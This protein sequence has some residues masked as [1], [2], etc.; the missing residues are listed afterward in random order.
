MNAKQENRFSMAKSVLKALDDNNNIVNALAA[1]AAAKTELNAVVTEIDTLTQAQALQTTAEEKTNAGKAAVVIAMEVIA[2]AKAYAL[3]KKKPGVAASFNYGTHELGK[4]RD[5]ILVN[6]MQLVHDNA[7]LIVADITDYG[8]DAAKLTS[9]QKA[10]DAY[11]G[12]LTAPKA[13][14][15]NRS[16]ATKGIATAFEKLNDVIEKIDNMV[17]TK[18]NSHQDFYNTYKAVRKVGDKGAKPKEEKQPPVQKN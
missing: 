16:A 2:A 1:L 9:L 15:A 7:K 4:M 12:L 17:E 18:R 11:A 3:D 6:T 8:A 14:M 5:T 10:I 13:N